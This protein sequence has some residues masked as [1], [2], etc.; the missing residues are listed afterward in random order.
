M[1]VTSIFLK[2][3]IDDRP[4]RGEC[5]ARGYEGQIDIESFNWALVSKL[6]KEG[7]AKTS[8]VELRQKHVKFSK[9]WDASSGK[10]LLTAGKLADSGTRVKTRFSTARFTF[11]SMVLAGEAG[12]NLGKMMELVLSDGEVEDVSLSTSE[13]KDSIGIKESVTLSYRKVQLLYY[14]LDRGTGSRAAPMAFELNPN[15]VSS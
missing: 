2:I 10:L 6:H 8:T 15:S 1:A 11:A 3:Y 5:Q 4:V 14:P 12:R 9:V 13:N 7:D